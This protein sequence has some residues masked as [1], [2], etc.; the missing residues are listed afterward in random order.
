MTYNVVVGTA[1]SLFYFVIGA[2]KGDVGTFSAIADLCGHRRNCRQCRQIRFCLFFLSFIA[3][4]SINLAIINILP[5]P[6]LDGGRLL[7][8]S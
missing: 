2:I 3:F 8:C 4:L 6:A 1:L 7:F 5:F